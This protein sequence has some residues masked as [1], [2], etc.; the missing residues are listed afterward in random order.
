M[1]NKDI[2]LMALFAKHSLIVEQLRSVRASLNYVTEEQ[3]IKTILFSSAEMNEGKSTVA[4][5]LAVLYAESG[6][7]V[8]LVDG[9]LR[10]PSIHKTFEL[11]NKR[12]LSNWLSGEVQ[13]LTD[14]ICKT[15]IHGL[16]VTTSGTFQRD[17]ATLLD[18]NKMNDFLFTAQKEFDI[19]MID[20]TPMTAVSDAQILSS[21]VDGT[22]IVI[23]ENV[24]K[25]KALK[26][27]INLLQLSGSNLLGMIY[28]GSR[29]SVYTGY[30]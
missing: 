25:K 28:N 2:P 1:T 7:R 22:L 6:K 10:N 11:V 9:D 8:L 15:G 24:T 27:T 23:R 13:N 21:K 26:K 4:A 5:N 14:V 20:T 3:G 30:H 18:S 17:P 16:H 19:V 29:K 12:G